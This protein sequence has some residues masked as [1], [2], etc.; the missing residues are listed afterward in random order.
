MEQ[1]LRALNVKCM[2]YCSDSQ[3]EPQESPGK[4]FKNTDTQG[5]SKRDADSVSLGRE[6]KHLYFLK[7][8]GDNSNLQAGLRTIGMVLAEVPC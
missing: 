6:L 8:S 7:S 5:P 4:I 3:Q 1:K 2:I